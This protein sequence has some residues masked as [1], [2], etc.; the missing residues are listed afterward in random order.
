M[1][2]LYRGGNANANSS[3]GES[4]MFSEKMPIIIAIGVVILAF[5]AVII[6]ISF[7]LR[8][9]NLQSK[10][11]LKEPV[12]LDDLRSPYLIDAVDIPKP[13]VGREYSYSFWLYIDAF[14][15]SSD[16]SPQ[17]IFYRGSQ[18]SISDANPIVMMDGSTNK[19]YMVLKTQG[20]SLKSTT[21]TFNYDTNLKHI[22]NRSYFLNKDFYLDTSDVHKHI[23]I[24]V[25]YVPL[26]RWVNLSFVIDNKL[27]TTF[28]DG[29]IYSVKSI[30][31]FKMMKTPEVDANGKVRDYSI[32]IEPTSGNI[33]LGRYG[34]S[35]T[36]NAYV[37]S[38]QF[39]NY[40]ASLNDI[41]AVYKMGP[42]A[43]SWLSYLGIN[44]YGIRSPI[45]P[46]Y[47]QQNK[48]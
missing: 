3:S 41:K 23:I 29:E 20:S 37:S 8:A 24:S 2:K 26:Q 39:F 9:A 1:R 33:Q 45:Y 10:R 17:M 28:M 30:D 18:T 25:D 32:I 36:P 42:F 35:E 6:Y 27:V 48:K 21:N 43:K 15:Q 34:P 40:A 47:Q 16:G 4:L 44:A 46:L 12:K 38:L 14:Q 19:L 7:A 11:L 22:L 13:A 5:I 31:E